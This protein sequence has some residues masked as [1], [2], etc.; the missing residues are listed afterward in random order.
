[1]M[2]FALTYSFLVNNELDRLANRKLFAPN[3]VLCID[4]QLP[5]ALSRFFMLNW[6]CCCDPIRTC[7]STPQPLLGLRN[8][9]HE[10]GGGLHWPSL[11]SHHPCS[12]LSFFLF[13]AALSSLA[14][15][16]P[17]PVLSSLAVGAESLSESLV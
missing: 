16:G 14:A 13:F 6:V 9:L 8:P 12:S 2:S 7:L 11:V 1:M 3:D 17:L 5:I 4:V 10:C 15:L